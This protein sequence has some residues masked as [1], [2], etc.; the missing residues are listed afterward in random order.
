MKFTEN[1]QVNWQERYCS[2]KTMP[3]AVQPKQSIQERI[4]ELQWE[5]VEHLPYSSDLVLSDFHLFGILKSHLGVR[6]FTDEEV[7]TEVQKWLRQQ[8]KDLHAAGFDTLVT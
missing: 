1:V 3:D 8:P 6:Y 2:I 5:L 4:Q 7:Q